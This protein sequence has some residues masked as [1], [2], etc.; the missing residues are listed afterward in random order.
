MNHF[1][2]S[3][4]ATDK[5]P[6]AGGD[7][8]SWFY[9]YKWDVGGLAYVPVPEEL[10]ADYEEVPVD[11]LRF[12]MD[13]KLLGCVCVAEILPAFSG[14]VELHYD[15]NM[16]QVQPEAAPEIRVLG[17]TGRISA[18]SE[19]QSMLDTLKRSMDAQYPPRAK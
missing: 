11:T 2:Y 3:M 13:T 9:Y 1:I 6:A 7:T 15:T 17:T 14:G 16:I 4:V 12:V 18:G 5:A 19:A 8:K 10:L